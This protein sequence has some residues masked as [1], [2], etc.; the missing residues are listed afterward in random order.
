M[1]SSHVD[2]IYKLRK[3][4]SIIGLTGRMSVGCTEVADRLSMSKKKFVE[5]K[6]VEYRDWKEIRH[7]EKTDGEFGTELYKR[8]HK[9]VQEYCEVNWQKYE[10]VDYNRVLL[11]YL[12][13]LVKNEANS[14]AKF[15]DALID[16]YKRSLE[17]HDDDLKG[18]FELDRKRLD[19]ICSKND[20]SGLVNLLK[21]VG[22][23]R[24]CRDENQLERLR[25][26][27][28]DSQLRKLFDDL[29]YYFDETNYYL[30]AFFFHKLA[31]RIRAHNSWEDY[32]KREISIENV[33]NIAKTIN[34][35]IKAYKAVNRDNCH[36]VIDGLKSSLEIM[37]FKERYSA[38]Y[39]MSMHNEDG[40]KDRLKDRIKHKDHIELTVSKVEDLDKIEHDSSDFGA[41]G[42]YGQDVENCIQKSEV[43]LRYN[44]DLPDYKGGPHNFTTL[45]EQ[46][47]KIQ[48]LIQ[49]PGIITPTGIER[50]M[51]VAFNSKFNSG[52]ISR[53]VGAVITDK[54][55]AIKSVGWND[56]PKN[57]MACLFRTVEELPK[58]QGLAY[59]EFEVHGFEFKYEENKVEGIDKTGSEVE[60]VT[61]KA[62]VGNNF[63]QNAT[64]VMKP[65]L[66]KVKGEGKNCAF[67]FKTLHN[68]F[69]GEK[70][71]VHTRSLH[72]EE[73]AMLQ[74]SKYGGQQLVGGILFTTASPCEL[75][76]KKAYQLG[77]AEVYFI[78]KYPGISMEHVLKT[79]SQIPKL[80]PFTGVIGKSFNKLYEPL[81]AYKD[82]LKMYAKY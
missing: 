37:F 33:Y 76:A 48:A 9:L 53:Q 13:E 42:F 28:F 30:E 6:G 75:C 46:L 41:R 54:G 57:V 19:E 55:R 38:F 43:H 40:Q 7:P 70:N 4:F 59:S 23:V 12:I 77:I 5:L 66:V 36:V 2:E 79:G 34:R 21:Q 67:C 64:E 39:M 3:S 51:Q 68:K 29:V 24:S 16:L 45:S 81:M 50:C 72:A 15:V 35:L 62:F 44:N 78:D 52:C 69:E 20:F 61:N 31:N 74:I 26:L 80:V 32:H 1:K 14:Q 8:K 71:Q 58:P 49:Q 56:T 73:N 63:A 25:T 18:G 82:E 22:D 47:M 17:G 27:F 60:V 10:V 11:L 65:T